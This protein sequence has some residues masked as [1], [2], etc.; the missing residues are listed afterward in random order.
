MQIR[1]LFRLAGFGLNPVTHGVIRRWM[2]NATALNGSLAGKQLESAV[3]RSLANFYA[4][5]RRNRCWRRSTVIDTP[6][7]QVRAH[8]IGTNADVSRAWVWDMPLIQG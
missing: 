7:H 4:T 3:T 1:I 5:C 8:I 2:L 6:A